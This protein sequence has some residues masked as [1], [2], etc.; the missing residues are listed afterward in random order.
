MFKAILV[1]AVQLSVG[2]C[3]LGN[4]RLSNRM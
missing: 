3:M 4:A 1:I 2:E